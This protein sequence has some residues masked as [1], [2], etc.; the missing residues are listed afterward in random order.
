MEE[1]GGNKIKHKLLELTGKKRNGSKENEW[2]YK[3]LSELKK[4]KLTGLLPQISSVLSRSQESSSAYC[5]RRTRL[6]TL[7]VER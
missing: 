4:K 6:R 5:K 7:E 2:R 1:L 3:R